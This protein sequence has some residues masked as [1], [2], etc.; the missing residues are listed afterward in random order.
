[1]SKLADRLIFATPEAMSPIN[2]GQP[3]MAM[4][5]PVGRAAKISVRSN[6][7]ARRDRPS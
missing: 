7:A 6:H 3:C 1:M 4:R 5:E 2:V